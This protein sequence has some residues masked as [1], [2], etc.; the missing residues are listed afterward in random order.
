MKKIITFLAF[1]L[2]IACGGKEGKEKQ[3]NSY[4]IPESTG[5]I[6]HIIV[7]VEP[8]HWKGK[9]GKAFKELIAEP[10]IGLPQPEF[11]FNISTI[12]P[13]AFNKMFQHS[14]NLLVLQLSDKETFR[15]TKDK[16][17]K[18]QTIVELKAATVDELVALIASKGPEMIDVFKNE[19]I[20]TIQK[21]NRKNKIA[22][23]I[24]ALSG[25]GVKMDIPN[26][27]RV[28]MD[29][30]NSF[31]WMRS[32]ISGGIANGDQTN[33]LLAYEAPMF[34]DSKPVLEQIIKNR[35]RV[36]KAYIRGNNVDKMYMI[37]EAA[38]T[39]VVKEIRIDG[40]KAYETR[41]TW[42]VFGAFNAGPFLNYSIIDKK[43]NRVVVVEGFNY[44]PSVNKRDFMF[45]LEAV[46]KT[47]TIKD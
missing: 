11:Q 40:K 23:K 26:K 2:L 39:P 43:N 36:G 45:E 18:P 14:R 47:T 8:Q 32:H 19:D 16:Y 21:E 27:Y 44:A 38:R 5:R 24:K 42:E 3:D 13:K 34:D 10:M 7:V 15:T 22:T 17:A 30:L 12:P 31:M 9:I 28:V 1:V 37:T 41:G 33:N 4:M 29:T 46:L 35:D 25:L 20:K 6:N